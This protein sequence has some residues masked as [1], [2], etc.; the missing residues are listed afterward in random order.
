MYWNRVTIQA[1]PA[2]PCISVADVKSRLRIETSAD[3]AL[4]TALV[5]GAEARIDGPHGIGY[6][7]MEQTWRL[8]LD[9]FPTRETILLPGAPIKSITQIEYLDD[10]GST[11]TVDAADYHVDFGSTPVRLVPAYGTTWPG[12]RDQ[13]GAVKVDYVLGE[14][15]ADNVPSDLIDAVCLIVGHRY[16]NREATTAQTLS[17]L[18]MGVEAIL[19]EYRQA[20]VTA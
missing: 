15:N 16:E 8:T 7:L 11:Q 5:K 12:T 19:A 9:Q 2:N 13:I 6:A 17:E 18:P 1:G 20:G 3:D 10:A 14:S 4:L